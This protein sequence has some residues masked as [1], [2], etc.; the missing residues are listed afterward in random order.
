MNHLGKIL[1][2][3]GLAVTA[4]SFSGQ[5]VEV[6][7]VPTADGTPFFRLHLYQEG[8]MFKTEEGVVTSDFTLN[9]KERKAIINGLSYWVSV[10]SPRAANTAPLDIA[11]ATDQKSDDN[12]SASSGYLPNGYTRLASALVGNKPEGFGGGALGYIIIDH[13]AHFDGEWYTESMSSLPRNGKMSDLP[14]TLAHELMHALGLA[15]DRDDSSLE[16]C[17]N[18]LWNNGLRDVNGKGALPGMAITSQGSADDDGNVF[19]THGRTP[20]C[21]VYFTGDHVEEVLQGARLSWPDDSTEGSVPGLPVNGW[22]GE[23]SPEFSH[24]ELQN[25]LMSHQGYRNWN[26]LMEAELAVMQDCGLNVDRRNFYGGSLYGDGLSVV[27]TNPYYARNAEGTGWKEGRYNMMSYGIGFHVYG[28]RNTIRQAADLLSAGSWG[29]GIRMDGSGN[30][31]YIDPGVRVHADGEGGNALLVSYGK[32]H[33]VVSGGDLQALGQ[34]GVAARFDF[35]SNE[36]GDY[37][38]MR[39]SFIRESWDGDDGEWNHEPLLEDLSGALVKSFDVTGRLSGAAAAILISSNAYVEEINIMSGAVLAGDI[40]SEWDRENPFIQE[41]RKEGFVTALTFGRKA[42]GAGCATQGT[43]SSFFLRYS[44]NI[45]GPSGIGMKLAAGKLIYNGHAD[46][47]SVAVEQGAVLEGTAEYSVRE[48]LENRGTLSPG[49]GL[50]TVTVRGNFVQEKTG[51]LFVELD[52]AGHYDHLVVRGDARVDGTLLLGIRRGYYQ[53]VSTLAPLEVSGEFV[54]NYSLACDLASPTLTMTLREEDLSGRQR[55]VITADRSADAY[56]RYADTGH[57]RQ[58]GRALD[59]IGGDAPEGMR[60]LF[61]ALDFSS[62][63]GRDIRDALP[64]LSADAYGAAALSLL[65]MQ[66]TLSDLVLAGGR[67]FLETARGRV[68]FAQPYT[69]ANNQP[70]SLGYKSYNMGFLGGVRQSGPGGLTYGGHAVFN[71]L[72]MNG[73]MDGKMRGN[74]FMLGGELGYA[75]Q[76]EGMKWNM[77]VRGGVDR[78]R[79]KR[80]VVFAGYDASHTADW[81]GFSGAARLLAV[82]DRDLGPVMAGPLASLDY[83]LATRPSVTED[84]PAA[85]HLHLNSGTFQSLRSRLGG[86]VFMKPVSMGRQSFWAARASVTWNHELMDRVGVTDASFAEAAGYG[87][88]DRVKFPSRDSIG[89]EAGVTVGVNRNVSVLAQGGSELFMHGNNSLYG[90]LSLIWNF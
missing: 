4:G 52:D 18:S 83:G 72:S 73:D 42:D 75:P 41:K 34:G 68:L 49:D 56:S 14:S 69:S 80:K 43:D 17:G 50:G 84:G 44:G 25:S 6:L 28:S 3:G 67:P 85:T 45:S 89:I 40:I 74:S 47:L 20:Y 31:L 62:S 70:E 16:F 63:D 26:I 65:N 78:M 38:E 27:N 37:E 10:L 53:G 13:A 88:S 22:E 66:R 7:D 33:H 58:V 46:V 90:S 60:G 2:A 76:P 59:R 48:S 54:R 8:E 87:F 21:G 71:Y 15:C 86:H 24:I 32:N 64:R 82:Y 51:T 11:I 61:S 36:L 23:A 79:M 1:I 39:G 19:V 29:M 77:L 9:E 12:A 35:G 57:A 55:I 5:A 30:T 81:T